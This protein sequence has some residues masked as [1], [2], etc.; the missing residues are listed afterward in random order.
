[1]VEERPGDRGRRRRALRRERQREERELL[2]RGRHRP[3]GVRSARVGE[4]V[5][6]HRAQRGQ[7]ALQRAAR[8]RQL[9]RR[10]RGPRR[11][12]HRAC[13][14]H[15]PRLPLRQP[16]QRRPRPQQPPQQ[17]RQRRPDRGVDQPRDQRRTDVL[18]GRPEVEQAQRQ[19][20]DRRH[21]QPV[22]GGDDQLD[23][24]LRDR[25]REHD[26]PQRRIPPEHRERQPDPGDGAGHPVHH[27]ATGHGEVA[28]L[29]HRGGGEAHPVG[30]A[31]P[32]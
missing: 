16:H 4:R 15:H 2:G 23:G 27:P 22:V 6:V 25:D 29:Q 31:E 8:L 32:Q 26:H 21:R 13:R 20:G 12:E 9:P 17:Q 30:M 10:S 11:R 19:H 5:G 14:G 24:E 7:F 18:R 1:M 3:A 28:A